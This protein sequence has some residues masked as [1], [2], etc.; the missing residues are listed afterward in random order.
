MATS[1]IDVQ[2]GVDRELFVSGRGHLIGF[3]TMPG[4]SSD[5]NGV[6]TNG[7]PGF[8][9]SAIFFNY[10]DTTGLK[11]RYKNVGSNTSAI[12]VLD[13]QS[14][15][16]SGTSAI[17]AV[18]TVG[19]ATLTAAQLLGRYIAR[20]GSQT[21]AFTDTTDTMALILA[22]GPGLVV[23]DAVM[24]TI[25]NN[26][27][28]PETIAA[29]SSITMAGLTVIPRNSWADFL[30][31]Y[32]SST[33]MTMTGVRTGKTASLPPQGAVTA[34]FAN[35]TLG[36]DVLGAASMMLGQL[37]DVMI[38][39]AVT[40]TVTLDSTANILAQIPNYGVGDYYH[41]HVMN[42][43]SIT[44][45]LAAGDAS[46]I[47]SGPAGGSATIASKSWRDYDMLLSSGSIT[48]T[49]TGGLGAASFGQ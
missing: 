17:A 3:A 1:R 40:G 47:L 33:A 15:S 18:N 2:S 19:A 5:T 12:W 49:S 26:T 41:L 25:D 13:A 24:I 29:G 21:A 44:L 23:N 7:I 35:A 14:S 20:G 6:P 42:N 4:T 32:T 11:V 30:L 34:T 9:P 22:A 16:P 31:K 45:T 28:Y 36:V 46:T 48:L 27:A 10:K 43:S 8:A 37:S 39:G 38:A